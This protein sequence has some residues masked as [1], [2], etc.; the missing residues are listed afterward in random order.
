VESGR[1]LPH[2]GG[3]S[4]R[5]IATDETNILAG[6]AGDAEDLIPRFEA[7]RTEDVLAPVMELLPTRAG[8]ILDVGAGTG[9]DSAWF[10]GQGHDVVAVE[11]VPEFRRAGMD[12]H[13]LAN[14]IWLDDRL[15]LLGTLA[16]NEAA[17]DLVVAIAVW[18]HLRPDQQPSAMLTLARLIA[19]KG[20]L[21]ISVRHGPGSPTRPC[22]H[23]DVD[24]MT[25][26]GEGAGLKLLMRREAD[27]VQQKNRDA[28]VRW[29]WLCMERD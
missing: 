16:A 3:V 8:R 26:W 4:G 2:S 1:W 12:L 27:S 18:Q 10:A 19:P 11:P 6:Y 29:T 13:R 21:I 17:F 22:F 15:P 28:G 23:A 24:R 9:R 7:L 20:R 14:L 5:Q 25:G